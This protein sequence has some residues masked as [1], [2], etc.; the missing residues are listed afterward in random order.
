MRTTSDRPS[1]AGAPSKTTSPCA[2]ADDPVGIAAG[3]FELM[4]AD[5][6]GDAVGLADIAQESEN[7]VG[8]G[9]IKTCDRLVGQDQGRVLHQCAGDADALLL[10]AGELVGA[11]QR[12]FEQADA[13]DGIERQPLLGGTRTAE[14]CAGRRDSRGGR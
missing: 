3:K 9:R 7:A 1:L 6:R 2:S 10:A 8:G 5:D 11:A 4:Q 14:A 13:V 12:I